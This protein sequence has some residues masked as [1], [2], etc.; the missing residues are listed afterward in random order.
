VWDEALVPWLR[1]QWSR[2]RY[3]RHTLAGRLGFLRRRGLV[4]LCRLGLMAGLLVWSGWS[5]CWPLSWALLSLPLAAALLS[6]LLLLWPRLLKVRVYPYLVRGVH[7]LYLP[8][9]MG[10]FSEGLLHLRDSPWSLLVG[11]RA[12]R[13]R[14][15]GAG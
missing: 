8:A 6:L 2:R 13:R 14:Y 4:L 15:L 3:R 10:L 12:G 9:L 11:G 7:D 1:R 5:Q